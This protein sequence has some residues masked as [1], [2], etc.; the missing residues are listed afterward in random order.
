MKYAFCHER[1]EIVC[2]VYVADLLEEN[3]VVIWHFTLSYS[4]AFGRLLLILPSNRFLFIA[5][6]GDLHLLQLVHALAKDCHY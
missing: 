2:F 6:D 3:C 1:N 4:L 5:D